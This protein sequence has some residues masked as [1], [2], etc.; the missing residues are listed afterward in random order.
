MKCV[1]CG[2]EMTPMEERFLI[3]RCEDCDTANPTRSGREIIKWN[4]ANPTDPPEWEGLTEA[5]RQR[6]ILKL[7]HGVKAI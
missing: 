5:Q 3:A 6:E 2:E 4:R 7:V 1:D